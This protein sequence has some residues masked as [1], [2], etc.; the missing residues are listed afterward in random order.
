M[1]TFQEDMGDLRKEHSALLSCCGFQ[2]LARHFHYLPDIVNLFLYCAPAGFG[3]I[4][5]FSYFL[6]LTALLLH[7]TG[8][9]DRRCHAKYGVAWE[10]YVKRVPYKLVPGVW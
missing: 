4:L 6:Y 1:L 7:R 3:R 9:I 5:P 10:K 8:R 2:G